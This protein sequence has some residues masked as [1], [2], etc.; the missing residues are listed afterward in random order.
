MSRTRGLAA[1]F[2]ER[3]PITV[4]MVRTSEERVSPPQR[5]PDWRPEKTSR[6]SLSENT[7]RDQT[8]SSRF[9][10]CLSFP[11]LLAKKRRRMRAWV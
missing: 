2:W 7:V 5:P 11:R 6:R 10:T 4:A 9:F 3:A 8:L 1:S